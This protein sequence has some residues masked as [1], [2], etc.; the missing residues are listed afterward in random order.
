MTLTVNT[1]KVRRKGTNQG[2]NIPQSFDM[3]TMQVEYLL[4]EMLGKR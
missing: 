4:S 3:V 2:K 1:G